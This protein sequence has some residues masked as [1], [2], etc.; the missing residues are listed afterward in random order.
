MSNTTSRSS[1]VGTDRLLGS[2]FFRAKI[3]QESLIRSGPVPYTIV[4][5]TQFFEF[6]ER[7]AAGATEGD[8][9]RLSPALIQPMAADDVAAAVAK[10]A[11]GTPLNDIAEVA[12]PEKF[13][14]DDLVRLALKTTGDDRQVITDAD[15]PYFGWVRLDER[16][17]IPGADAALGATRFEDWLST[18]DAHPQPA[19]VT[20]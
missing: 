12:G 19:D 20:S 18:G 13:G 14:L 6:V 1:V 7:I 9:V 2:G 11:V 15:A 5:A 8:T 16:T 10:A 17:L 4:R 3:V